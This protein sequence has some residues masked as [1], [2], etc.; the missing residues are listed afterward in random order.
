MKAQNIVLDK[1][2]TLT[3]IN[4]LEPIT[5]STLARTL[6]KDIDPSLLSTILGDLLLEGL[7]SKDKRY[8][9][10]TYRGISLNHSQSSKKIRD[11]SRMK[12]LLNI[13]KQRGGNF[14]GR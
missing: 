13:S 12:F 14:V 9:R 8:F 5:E 11:I 7:I 2:K 4:V 3:A 10:I 6:K 1:M